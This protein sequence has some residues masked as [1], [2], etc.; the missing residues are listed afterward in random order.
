MN[1]YIGGSQMST[2][3]GSAVCEPGESARKCS[4]CIDIGSADTLPT[5]VRIPL[6]TKE[7]SNPLKKIETVKHSTKPYLNPVNACLA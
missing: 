5:Q 6:G 3:G 2:G 4:E 1:I 7:N